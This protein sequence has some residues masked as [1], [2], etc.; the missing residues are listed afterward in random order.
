M[1]W[2]RICRW[3]FGFA[4]LLAATLPEDTETTPLEPVQGPDGNLY[5]A[6][7]EGSGRVLKVT[8]TS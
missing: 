3:K 6:T 1:L 7:D 5:L 2:S 8:P 4:I